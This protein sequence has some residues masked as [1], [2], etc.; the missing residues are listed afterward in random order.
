[1]TVLEMY[2]EIEDIGRDNDCLGDVHEDRV[3]GHG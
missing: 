2:M 1:M 3:H